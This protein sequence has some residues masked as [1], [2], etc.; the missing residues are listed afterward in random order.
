MKNIKIIGVIILLFSALGFLSLK[1][2]ITQNLIIERAIESMVDS[3]FFIFP[4]ED[5]LTAVICSSKKHPRFASGLLILT[6]NYVAAHHLIGD[7][8]WL[9]V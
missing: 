4:E 5:S 6:E 7:I 8:L 1:T 9:K 2:P 3:N